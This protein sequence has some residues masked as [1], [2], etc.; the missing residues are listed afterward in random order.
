MKG[1]VLHINAHLSSVKCHKYAQFLD[2]ST[3]M[4]A[5]RNSDMYAFARCSQLFPSIVL[6]LKSWHILQQCLMNIS[7]STLS[8]LRE[9]NQ[10]GKKAAAW[11][12]LAEVSIQIP[13]KICNY[14]MY[15]FALKV[16][17]TAKNPQG[18]TKG[19]GGRLHMKLSSGIR[20]EK[21]RLEAQ[22]QFFLCAAHAVIEF[23]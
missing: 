23:T 22:S 9:K 1:N 19:G 3:S 13:F 2:I 8:F 6:T 18:E 4:S 20:D 10:D 11:N 12:S 5:H 21:W 17:V 16:A 14:Y 7:P 15:P